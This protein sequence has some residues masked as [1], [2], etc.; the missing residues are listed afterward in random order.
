M[1]K[2]KVNDS[3]EMSLVINDEQII[4][5]DTPL[6]FDIR[7]LQETA[8]SVIVNNKSYTLF[9][10]Q[11][12][13]AKKTITI[14][15]N[16]TIYTAKINEPIDVLLTNMGMDMSKMQKTEPIKAPMPGLVLKILV[17]EGQQL[18]KG[19]PVLILEA[20]KMENVFKAPNDATVKAILVQTGKAVEKGEILIDLA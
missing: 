8:Y 7:Q 18:K 11:V 3:Q 4:V 20:M 17:E 6:A 14:R 10:E 2:I 1:Y 5:N 15:V 12:D 9:V 13:K 16:G 19:D